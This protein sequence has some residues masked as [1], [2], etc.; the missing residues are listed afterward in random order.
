MKV[1]VVIPAKNEEETIT[2][3]IKRIPQSCQALVVDDG[4]TDKTAEKAYQAGALV[5]QHPRSRGV[6]AAFKTGL[7]VALDCGAEII[8]NMDADGQMF[9]EDIKVMV[10]P[11]ISGEAD[12]T[13]ANR[14]H[15]NH[16]PFKMPVLKRFGNALFSKVTSMATRRKFNDAT[17]GFRAYDR[18]TAAKLF[19]SGDFTY[20]QESL[21]DLANK[22]VRITEVPVYIKA[23]RKGKSKVVSS[24]WKYGF[25]AAFIMLKIVRDNNP[26]KFFMTPGVILLLLSTAAGVALI[27]RWFLGGALMDY[28]WLNLLTIM[29]FFL[30]LAFVIFAL[31]ADMLGR[32][33]KITEEIL[34]RLK[35]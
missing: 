5:V 6:G 12:M 25:R 3:V 13:I 32:Q 20:T 9:P 27:T 33:R 23:Q 34:Y 15:Y 10:Q 17:C 14:F 21:I 16:L 11:I 35:R 29:V 30:G 2:Q 31:V 4:S 19:V 7:D 18:D 28:P 22:N 24:V 26:L 1:F 8:V